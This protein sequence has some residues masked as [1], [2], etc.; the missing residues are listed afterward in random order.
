L[1]C[2]NKTRKDVFKYGRFS[3]SVQKTEINKLFD[4]KIR[5]YAEKRF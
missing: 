1:D 2:K 5:Y 4:K 3:S